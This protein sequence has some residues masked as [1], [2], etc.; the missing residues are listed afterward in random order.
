ML[1]PNYQSTEYV[2]TT[3]LPA[4]LQLASQEVSTL[5]KDTITSFA[6]AASTILSGF[7]KGNNAAGTND[8]STTGISGPIGV[9]KIGTDMVRTGDSNA[10][11]FFAAGIVLT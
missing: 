10:V 11:I 2:R 1:G 8:L 3:N 4:A 6:D 9:L 7:T 5:A